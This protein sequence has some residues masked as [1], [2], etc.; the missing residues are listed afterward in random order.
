MMPEVIIWTAT[1]CKPCAAL[2]VWTKLH[3]PFVVYKDVEI[4]VA[5]S[6]IKSVPTLQVNQE[7]KTGMSEI[8]QYLTCGEP[9]GRGE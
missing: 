2:K 6:E 8:K 1:W 4:D 3:F 7:F 5:P 9:I